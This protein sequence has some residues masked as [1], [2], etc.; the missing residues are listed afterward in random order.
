MK[1]KAEL[2]IEL[3]DN[4]DLNAIEDA[5]ICAERHIEWRQVFDVKERMR[6]TDLTNK[7]GSCKYFALKPDLTSCCYGRCEQGYK[8]Y[9]TRAHPGCKKYERRD[10]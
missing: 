5:K 6:K 9:K 3:P 2:V 7:C 1:F 4:A 10:G 8:G